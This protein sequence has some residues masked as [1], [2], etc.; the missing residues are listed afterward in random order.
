[1]K[2]NKILFFL[3]AL[4]GLFV[5]MFVSQLIA[6]H[7]ECSPFAPFAV[8]T[9]IA[10]LAETFAPQ[11]KRSRNVLNDLVINDT[12]YSG[13]FAS[14]FWIPA[15]FGLDSVRKG[16]TYVQDGIKKKHTIGRVDYSFPLQDRIPTPTSGGQWT[17]DGRVLE[18][19]SMM[20]YTEMLPSLFEAHWLAEQLSP[21]LLSRKVPV[22]AENYMLQI[23]L[24]RAFE[25]IETGIWMGS[26]AYSAIPFDDPSGKGQIKYFNGF[27][28]RIVNDSS[29][30]AYGSPAAI[31]TSNIPTFLDG[32]IRLIATN[33]K[34]MLANPNRYS[35]LKFL[36]S[37]NTAEIYNEYITT[38]LTFKGLNT[39][40]QGIKP[41]K[42]YE[43]VPIAGVPDDTII[44]CEALPDPS[45]NLYIGMNSMEDNTLE[46]NRVQNNSELYFM[47]GLMKYDVQ[48]GFSD[49]IAVMTTLTSADF[50]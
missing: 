2:N 43:I 33:K 20:A 1:M 6:D 3:S 16:I 47:K 41:W 10:L 7:F 19:Q 9:F 27:M 39:M 31:T 25:S 45:S 36:V 12:S 44:F 30:L 46:I 50:L 40:E 42:G 24:N 28:Q 11:G 8:I 22:T 35:R 15:T 29:V 37:I 21:T 32:L 34:A 26:T 17:I 48:Y 18:P 23:M 13:T 49:Q 4:I 5:A 38:G 14:Y